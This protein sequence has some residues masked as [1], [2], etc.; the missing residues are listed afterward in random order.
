LIIAMPRPWY[1]S[2]FVFVLRSSVAC[3][4]QF[5]GRL[6]VCGLGR[7]GV[8]HLGESS[9][10]VCRTA[11]GLLQ[12]TTIF[13]LRLTMIFF[14]QPCLST[15]FIKRHYEFVLRWSA[16]SSLV[17]N[18]MAVC[19]CSVWAVGKQLARKAS[20]DLCKHQLMKKNVRALNQI[21]YFSSS[22]IA[23]GTGQELKARIACCLVSVEKKLVNLN[24]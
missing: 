6:P 24:L 23:P 22:V 9:P 8:D 2:K 13:F 12:A 7:R 16:C 18:F 14:S 15:F 17:S 20:L 19:P 3:R 1:T 5:H 11:S 10:K 4:Q 21:Q